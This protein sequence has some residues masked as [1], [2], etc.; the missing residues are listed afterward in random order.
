MKIVHVI[1][2]LCTGGAE[3]MLIDILAKQVEQGQDVALVVINNDYEQALINKLPETVRTV[4]IDRPKG[5]RNPLWLLKYNYELLKLRPDVVHFHHDKA[6]GMFISKL[7]GARTLATVH[8]TKINLKYYLNLDEVCSISNSVRLDLNK[9]YGIEAP[10]VYNGIDSKS[11]QRKVSE[12]HAKNNKFYIVQVSRLNH[13]KKGQDL[14]IEAVARLI[15]EGYDVQLDFVG[16]GESEQQLREQASR[17]GIE[18]H[19]NFLGLKDRNYIYGHLCDYDL[20]VQPSRYE[21]FG[22]T[23]AEAMIAK[24]PVLVSDVE[25]PMEVIGNGLYGKSFKA[26]SVG[27]LIESL[28]AV[29]E[30]YEYSRRIAEGEAYDFALSSFD[31]SET[32][33]KYIDRYSRLLATK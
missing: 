8:D 6:A 31:I 17:L 30:N 9:R 16:E 2:S 33:K 13:E 10:I 15:N 29:L 3:L 12:R 4:L 21:G 11:I 5:S 18:R 7:F 23:V 14:I 32:A 19:V 25:G 22:L 24:V 1:C 28:Q 20:L 26:G 27:S